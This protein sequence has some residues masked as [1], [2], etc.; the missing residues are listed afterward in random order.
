MPQEKG[1]ISE[2]EL[3]VMKVVWANA[4]PISTKEICEAVADRQWKRTTISTLLT[5]LVEKG[6][7]RGTRQGNT[8]IYTPL[9]E[10]RAYRCRQT[11]SL[12]QRLFN[13]SAKDFAAAMV[14]DEFLTEEDVAE[15]KKMFDL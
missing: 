15:L 3:A 5:R 14:E 10:E 2:A 4:G 1:E 8:T 7:L 12:I 11:K 13:G 9:L 6:A